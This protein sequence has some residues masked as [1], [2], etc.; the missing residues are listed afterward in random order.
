MNSEAPDMDSGNSSANSWFGYMNS[1]S[2][3]K[4]KE[5][6]QGSKYF[7]SYLIAVALF[8]STWHS[9]VAHRLSLRAFAV[10][11]ALCGLS[12]IYGCLFIKLTSFSFKA[13]HG[14]STQFLCGYLVLNTLLFL[15][16]LFTPFTMAT[17]VFILAA[18]G[19]VILLSWPIAIKD[20]RQPVDYLPDFLC[21][22]ISGIAATLWCTDLLSAVVSD[23][24]NTV[25]Q[26]YVDSFF[27][28]RQISN[29]AQA[30]GLK[31]IS[32]IRMSGRP[33]GMY[34]Y[35]IYVAP[36]ALSLFTKS[37]AYTTFV[38]FLV[39][40]GILFTGLAAFSLPGPTWGAGPGI[41]ATLAV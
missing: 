25:Y 9:R 36:A 17:N 6:L 28:V 39:P 21:L 41:P 30:H 7:L 4:V 8:L 27:H 26:T 18:F 1:R 2:L 40:F 31:T 37:S 11:V 22:L 20:I 23:G 32:D 3:T 34:H 14:L 5:R 35:A 16:S 15:L 10:F 33:G 13:A 24:Q 38:S 19:L 12:L 29:F